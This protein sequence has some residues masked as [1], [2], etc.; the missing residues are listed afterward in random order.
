M[1]TPE[2]FTKLVEN[3]N[4][5]LR[6]LTGLKKVTVYDTGNRWLSVNRLM[7]TGSN[8]IATV[9]SYTPFGN[10]KATEKTCATISSHD[11][12]MLKM[13]STINVPG[14]TEQS[15]HESKF[16]TVITILRQIDLHE[17]N[18][19]LKAVL[20]ASPHEFDR[21][22]TSKTRI[23]LLSCM[24]MAELNEVYARYSAQL[25]EFRSS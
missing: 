24:S 4:N 3:A 19:K 22:Q 6:A 5:N 11:Y 14:L 15:L 18:P 20:L 16:I 10:I 13:L 25:R 21:K 17:S 8:V 1:I 9:H 23:G 12:T 2:D 7:D